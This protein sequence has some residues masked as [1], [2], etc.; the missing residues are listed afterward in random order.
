M[1][2]DIR[3]PIGLLFGLIGSLLLGY[4]LFGPANSVRA[5]SADLNCGWG[6][7]LIVFGVGMLL[8]AYRHAARGRARPGTA[9]P[10]PGPG[11]DKPD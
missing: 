8:L 10:A 9:G 3:I 2:L 6:A 11:A 4:G 5:H 1:T 7:M